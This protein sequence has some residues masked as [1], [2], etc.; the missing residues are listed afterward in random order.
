VK[1]AEGKVS[2]K[3]LTQGLGADF[4]TLNSEGEIQGESL[5]FRLEHPKFNGDATMSIHAQF[6]K[7]QETDLTSDI[8]VHLDELKIQNDNKFKK[9]RKTPLQLS[10]K[11][12][13]RDPNYNIQLGT[14]QFHNLKTDIKGTLVN[15][16]KLSAQIRSL[17]SPTLLDGWEQF[18]PQLN[19]IKTT[20][21]IEGRADFSGTFDDLKGSAIDLDFKAKGIKIPVLKDWIPSKNLDIQ[22]LAQL[23]SELQLA[24]SGGILKKLSTNTSINLKETKITYNGLFQKNNGTPLFA[25]LIIN[26]SAQEAKIKK[27]LLSLGNLHGL[28]TGTITNFTNPNIEMHLNFPSLNAKEIFSFYT[29]ANGSQLSINSGTITSQLNLKGPALS[30]ETSPTLSFEVKPTNLSFNYAHN[31]KSSPLSISRM[32]GRIQGSTTSDKKIKVSLSPITFSSLGGST[33]IQGTCQ[34]WENKTDCSHQIKI[35]NVEADQ[36]ITFLSPDSKGVVYGK[37]KADI[38]NKFA[39]S[40]SEDIQKSIKSQ[41]AF[42]LANG[43]LNTVNFFKGPVELLKKIPGVLNSYQDQQSIKNTVGRFVFEN[44]R[45]AILDLKIN[46]PYFDLTTPQILIDQKNNIN[47]LATWTPKEQLIGRNNLDLLRDEKGNASIPVTVRGTLTKPSL[48]VDKKVIQ[49]RLIYFAKKSAAQRAETMLNGAKNNITPS[50][51]NSLKN[52]LKQLFKN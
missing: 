20:G 30:K 48:D 17:I 41:G 35:N 6:K 38:S 43:K 21:H 8:S 23:N 44:G 47:C 3:I 33:S 16:P 1:Q 24:Y 37:L 42:N 22:G 50:V 26:S 32:A 34:F 40:T 31:Q 15:G 11:I 29:G 36:F 46:S 28:I 49:S 19:G 14:F 2:L 10:L 45:L 25:D 51:E 9:P 5:L 18:F 13:G 12:Q 39:G 52:G 7:A 27:G 4:N